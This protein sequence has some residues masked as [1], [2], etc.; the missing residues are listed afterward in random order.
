[1]DT[2]AAAREVNGVW[3]TCL[4]D[5]GIELI[6]KN[7]PSDHKVEQI[8][9]KHFEADSNGENGDSSKSA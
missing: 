5:S 4:I 8:I 7:C 3:H 9:K 2:L 6:P 1:M